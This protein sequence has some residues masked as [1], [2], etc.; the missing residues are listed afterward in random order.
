MT[1]ELFKDYKIQ[2]DR[3]SSNDFVQIDEIVW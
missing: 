3:N 1:L 2:I